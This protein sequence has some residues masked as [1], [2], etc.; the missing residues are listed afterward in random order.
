[1]AVRQCARAKNKI[2]YFCNCC[3]LYNG[4]DRAFLKN[5]HL[6]SNLQSNYLERNDIQV[7]TF[8]LSSQSRLLL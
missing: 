6:Q 3:Q 4:Y 8:S 2:V 7:D 1:M 5:I